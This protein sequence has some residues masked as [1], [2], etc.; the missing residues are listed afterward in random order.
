MISNVWGKK[1]IMRGTIW[2]GNLDFN[3]DNCTLLV[4]SIPECDKVLGK[5]SWVVPISMKENKPTNRTSVNTKW[6]V[7]YECSLMNFNV[8]IIL[9]C[10]SNPA[11]HREGWLNCNW[12]TCWIKHWTSTSLYMP[13]T[14]HLQKKSTPLN[15]LSDWVTP[16]HV[17]Q[18]GKHIQQLYNIM[19]HKGE[20]N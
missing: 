6:N 14:V 8:I 20:V 17:I 16:Y 4:I 2:R 12:H 10:W 19:Y 3:D 13:H 5:P 11:I 18:P 9:L 15:K 1:N 7:G